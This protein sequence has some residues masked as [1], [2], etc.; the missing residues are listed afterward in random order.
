MV[1]SLGLGLNCLDAV[2][3]KG[4]FCVPL[5]DVLGYVWCDVSL[6]FCLFDVFL[7]AT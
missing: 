1:L 3:S 2:I 4:E 6:D 5:F 7:W